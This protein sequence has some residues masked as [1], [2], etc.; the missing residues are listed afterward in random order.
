MYPSNPGVKCL[1]S[2]HGCAA[3]ANNQKTLCIEET[4]KR[5][6]S[7]YFSPILQ[8]THKTFIAQTEQNFTNAKIATKP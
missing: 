1:C 3:L 7:N 6:Q 8:K 5:K 4:K 2:F